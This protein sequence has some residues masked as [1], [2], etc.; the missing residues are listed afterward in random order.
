V[1]ALALV[2]I[3]IATVRPVRLRSRGGRPANV[4]PAPGIQVRRDR[5]ALRQGPH[6]LAEF[7]RCPP[8]RLGGDI[9]SLKLH[10]AF[11]LRPS[12][13]TS[14]C[15]FFSDRTMPISSFRHLAIGA[16]ITVLSCTATAAQT[17]STHVPKIGYVNAERILQESVPAKLARAR[18][19]A[20]FAPRQ[21]DI[22]AASLKRQQASD[23][24]EKEAPT[25]TE[26]E[27][28]RRQM[29]VFNLDRNVQRLQRAYNDDVNQR[30]SQELNN[31]LD[32][33][34]KAIRKIALS[35]G[36]DLILQDAIFVGPRIDITDR[37][38]KEL[39]NQRK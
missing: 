7:S 26:G 2:P 13:P 8:P 39:A 25:M 15:A 11:R 32:L 33:S 17:P 12:V 9:D 6:V 34:N 10:L 31:I 20:E 18:I 19:E 3:H 14:A 23:A 16:L 38:L 29:E 28:A 35:E 5:A 21:K 36:F 27:R 4:S 1:T 30:K 24:Y 37:V 22:D